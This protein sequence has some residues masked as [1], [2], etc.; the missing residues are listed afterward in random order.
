MSNSED[1]RQLG[2]QIFDMRYGRE[3]H[4]MYEETI[5]QLK[6]KRITILMMKREKLDMT[7]S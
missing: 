3:Q 4:Q 5:G 7:H 6:E 2:E 1:I